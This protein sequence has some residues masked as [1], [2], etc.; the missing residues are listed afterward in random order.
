MFAATYNKLVV[1]SLLNDG[2]LIKGEGEYSLGSA[3]MKCLLDCNFFDG[4]TVG[5]IVILSMLLIIIIKMTQIMN[6]HG[7]PWR[8]GQFSLSIPFPEFP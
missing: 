8:A 7:Q 2:S 3:G 6:G 1:D 5:S 4:K